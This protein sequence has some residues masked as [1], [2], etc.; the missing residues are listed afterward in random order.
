MIFGLIAS[1]T[2]ARI[3]GPSGSGAYTLI[4]LVS[5]MLVTFGSLGIGTS[6][7]YFIAKRKFRPEDMASNSVLI[8][9]GLGL[10]LATSFLA[11]LYYFNPPFLKDAD[12]FYILIAMFVLPFSLLT[13]FFSPLLL[14]EQR[15]RDY[16]TLPLI[17]SISG[18]CF[19]LFLFI[20]IEKSVF[21]AIMAWASATVVTAIMAI[22]FVS[23]LT[24]IRLSFNYFLFKES[25][26]FGLQNH[27]GSAVS[28]LSYRLNMFLV[29]FFM[30]ITFVGYLSIATALAE[31][32]L[33]L[34]TAVGTIMVART[35]RLSSKDANESSPVACR[36]TIFLSLVAASLVFIFGGIIINMIFGA[37]FLPA[38]EPLRIFLPGI[39]SLSINKVLCYELVGRGKPLVGSLAGLVALIINIPLNIILIPTWGI[40]GAALATTIS[41]SVSSIIPL[42]AFTRISQNSLLDTLVIKRQDLLIY[43]ELYRDVKRLFTK[44][45]WPLMDE[46]T[47]N[48]P[49]KGENINDN[50]KKP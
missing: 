17:Q 7:L 15:I 32:L 44:P 10:L 36:N 1:I 3:L 14:G 2:I 24:S 8:A 49:T 30:N 12:P 45:Q 47:H 34:P 11:Y 50:I 37:R 26:K 40:S 48:Q 23:K 41:Y 28:F 31:T 27:L 4:I 39:V 5:S 43:R 19:L 20:F 35:P 9:S 38:L 29:N 33:Y 22:Q 6:N 21:S 42:Y 18:L 25:I 46:A 13:S 16:N